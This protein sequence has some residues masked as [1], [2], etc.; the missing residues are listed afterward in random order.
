MYKILLLDVCH[1]CR[2]KELSKMEK[3]EMVVGP[4]ALSFENVH[5]STCLLMI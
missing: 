2:H 4:K 3:K 5:K 1:K